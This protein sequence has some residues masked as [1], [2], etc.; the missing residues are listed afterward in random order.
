MP[1]YTEEIHRS[2]MVERMFMKHKS[3]EPVCKAKPNT[4]YF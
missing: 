2:L 1:L 4:D 3:I